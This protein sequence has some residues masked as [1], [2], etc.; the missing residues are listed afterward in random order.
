MDFIVLDGKQKEFFS[1]Q[2]I[3]MMKISDK[4]F[5]PPLS[6][7]S[8]TLQTDLTS[9]ACSIDGI[10]KYYQEMNTQEILCTIENGVV[11]GFVSFRID[12]V[13][14]VITNENLPNIYLSTLILRPEARGK[15]LT[16]RMYD[17]LFNTLY[18]DR[19]IFTRTWSTNFAHTKILSKFDF[20]EIYRK[21]ND[22]GENIDT[23]YFAKI[24]K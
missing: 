22:R 6:A 16:V 9:G 2:I 12:F 17:H 10:Y 1:E 21:T 14:E 20:E 8:S 24:R 13:N 7:R 23:V 19:S 5:I 3:E 15:N 4:D 18:A 11:L